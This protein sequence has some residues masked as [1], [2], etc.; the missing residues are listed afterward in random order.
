M[1]SIPIP[2]QL[3]IGDTEKPQ[4]VLV[5]LPLVSRINIFLHRNLLCKIWAFGGSP[6]TPMKSMP[7][8]YNCTWKGTWWFHLPSSLLSGWHVGLWLPEPTALD[9]SLGAVPMHI[10]PATSSLPWNS[11]CNSCSQFLEWSQ[12]QLL[13]VLHEEVSSSSVDS[14][15]VPERLN[16]YIPKAV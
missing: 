1:R 13:G 5:T 9:W 2:L 14:T 15:H 10:D 3:Y 4:I 16:G 12:L 7:K 11:C 6:W 8:M